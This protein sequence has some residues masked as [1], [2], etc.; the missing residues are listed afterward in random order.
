M[1]S[2]YL[3]NFSGV[4]G[5]ILLSAL[6]QLVP[7]ANE[8]NNIL[9]K[10]LEFPVTLSLDDCSVN[11]IAAKKLNIAT[12]DAGQLNYRNID[13]IN[14]LIDKSPVDKSTRED[15]RAVIS[16]L[17]EAE[18]IVHNVPVENVHFHELGAIDTIIDILGVSFL[19]NNL[20]PLNIISAPLKVGNGFIKTCHGIIPNPAPATLQI[21]KEVTIEKM[22]IEKELTTPTG[23]ALI[24]YFAKN[25]SKCFN[26]VINNCFYSTGTNVFEEIPNLFC[27]IQFDELTNRRDGVIEIETNIDDMP[28]LN[29]SFVQ[30]KL[31]Q[32][33]A[34]DVYF[35]PV[36]TK[37]NRPA[38][39]LNVL[40][41]KNAL[42]LMSDII[43]NNTTTAGLRYT[44]KNR[45]ILKREINTI[46]YMDNN[47]RIKSLFYK[48]KIKKMP[49]WD[50]IEQAALNL[51]IPPY[52]L[53]IKILYIL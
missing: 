11:G 53:Y 8:L 13:D 12:T 41:S 34:L 5:D 52:E 50:D 51:N 1:N 2:I 37:K 26:G 10:A 33:G 24:K 38:Y 29:F 30:K 40:C 14:S 21:L 4:S 27:L 3:N 43:F 28:G 48:D 20:K 6:L 46:N 31:L 9:S 15:A 17:A 39:K 25:I 45:L 7:L 42:L 16:I 19:I 49:E 35:T 18:S 22:N 44:E 23:A 36:Y 32:A 47:I